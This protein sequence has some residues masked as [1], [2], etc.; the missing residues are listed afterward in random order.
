MKTTLINNLLQSMSPLT[1][2]KP[3]EIKKSYTQYILP[4]YVIISAIF[5]LLVAYSYFQWVVYNS[6]ALRWQQQ[7]YEAAYVE[8]VNAV[9]QKC[10]AVALEVWETTVSVVNV[11]C[12]EQPT[13]AQSLPA[14][15]E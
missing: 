13:Q 7:W 3:V 1:K 9:S 2:A 10:E 4:A 6:G 12:I 15:W 14:V 11:A 8:I 5:I